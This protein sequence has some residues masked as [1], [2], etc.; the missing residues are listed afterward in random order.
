MMPFFTRATDC[1]PLPATLSAM[2]DCYRPLIV[3]APNAADGR[4]KEQM[5]ELRSHTKELKERDMLVLVIIGGD[6]DG[7]DGG[8]PEMQ[9]IPSTQLASGE[10]DKL[11]E[12]FRVSRDEFAVLLVG[13]DGGEKFRRPVVVPLDALLAKIDSMPMRQQEMQRR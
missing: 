4:L 6:G 12:T 3:F 10:G 1:P 2:R 11:R 5:E 8:K 9:S 13:K 7:G